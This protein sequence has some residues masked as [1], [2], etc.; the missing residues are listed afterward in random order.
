MIA[1]NNLTLY[2][3]DGRSVV[4]NYSIS[5]S[6]NTANDDFT[7]LTAKATKSLI[8]NPTGFLQSGKIFIGDVDNTI[9]QKFITGDVSLDNSGFCTI[10]DNKITDNK[11][12]ENIN[13][14]NPSCSNQLLTDDST[15]IANT[16]YVK[17]NL[18][19]KQDLIEAPINNNIVLINDLGQVKSSLYSIK[20]NDAFIEPSSIE[21]TDN[22]SI[23]NFIN[24]LTNST[25]GLQPVQ[26]LFSTNQVLFGLPTQNNYIC[27]DNDRVI[28]TGQDDMKENLI[29]NVHINAWTIATDSDSVNNLKNS[30]VSINE[31]LNKSDY[32]YLI[33]IL[34]INGDI[35]PT[36]IEWSQVISQSLYQAGSGLN[37]TGSIFSLSDTNV[38]P[39]QYSINGK[40]SILV[41]SKGQIIDSNNV[42]LSSTDLTNSENI[43]LD[44][45]VSSIEENISNI[46]T[47]TGNNNLLSPGMIQVKESS[48][49]QDG[50]LSALN[51]Q[52]FNNKMNLIL[53]PVANNLVFQDQFGQLLSSNYSIN[54]ISS[55][56]ELTSS[57]LTITGTN[58]LLNSC[59]I[60]VKKSTNGQNGYLSSNDYQTFNNK[61]DLINNP[62][63]NNIVLSDNQG[64]SKIS[65]FSIKSNSPFST[66]LATE[67]PD[68]LSTYTYI[69]NLLAQIGD[70]KSSLR[71]A[72]YPG[73]LLWT[74]GRSLSRTT[75]ASLYNFVISDNL[76]TA[77]LFTAGNGS[78]TFTLGDINGRV[79]GIAG[80]GTGLT[81][82][83]LGTKTGTET[84][85]LT[86]AQLP[87]HT[88]TIN[89]DS[90]SG[91]G[92]GNTT[93]RVLTNSDGQIIN[94]FVKNTGAAGSDQ[95]HQNMQ[96]S[97]FI[98]FFIYSGV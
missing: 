67:I 26:L 88:H 95:A 91:I 14:R 48:I 46:L 55:L 31:G 93:D 58:N 83:T 22:L 71:S 94:T 82:R 92:G 72:D 39:N 69:N 21:L 64:N 97:L 75:Y 11:I 40:N 17:R 87:S 61:M 3:Q 15:K 25:N 57:V 41:N 56:Q 9:S 68:V 4:S 49:N 59:S 77:G 80:A 73:W 74:N 1:L 60:E 20:T 62:I 76:I 23:Y 50:Y 66:P 45:N 78:T 90:G 96:P 37:L 84:H 79:I 53:N 28:C 30:W 89:G 42:N 70:I 54:N 44:T 32:V 13:L 16:S 18:E 27:L 8:D 81:T 47:I 5:N 6:E 29:Y 52:A 85:V 7:I 38:V 2:Q 35:L 34:P 65:T 24:S 86:A 12:I 10:L 63:N 19:L 33:N 43:L 98:N 36:F 51:F